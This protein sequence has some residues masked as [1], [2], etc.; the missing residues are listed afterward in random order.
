MSIPFDRFVV[1][2][3]LGIAAFNAAINASYTFLLWRSKSILTLFTQNAIAFDLSSTS[4]WI[5]VLS[6]LLG[7]ASI[8]AKL[9]DGRVAA[10]NL[11]V[12]GF[13]RLMPEN[14]LMRAVA[15]GFLSAVMLGLP[16]RL[17]L[18]AG[19]ADV[20]ALS[21]AVLLKV[22]ITVPMSLVIVPLIIVAA[23]GDVRARRRFTT[24]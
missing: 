21:D 15:A 5:A 9:R 14:I 3:A 24:T 20:L 16:V 6:T 12:P 22:A 4:G 8:R 11:A 18:Q 23:V 1:T 7:T 10:P 13:L 17:L 2:Q 19:G